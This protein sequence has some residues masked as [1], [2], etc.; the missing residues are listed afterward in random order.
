MISVAFDIGT[1]NLGVAA[2]STNA[3]GE[4]T[5]IWLDT[6][7]IS[8][9]TADKCVVKLWEY[10]DIMLT[11]FP[12][13]DKLIVLI[14]AQPSKARSLMRSVEL[15]VRH[16]FMMRNHQKVSK[17]CVKSV[18][19]RSKLASAVQYVPGSS[20]A[21]RYKARKNASVTEVKSAFRNLPD[22]L[23]LLECCK[24]DDACDATLYLIRDGATNFVNISSYALCCH[25]EKEA[26]KETEKLVKITRKEEETSHRERVQHEKRAAKE[27]TIQEKLDAKEAVRQEKLD[28]KEAVRQEKLAANEAGRQE[29]LAAKEAGRQEKTS[30]R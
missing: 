5:L 24:A 12:P 28:A 19:P 23:G 26:V 20:S 22:A 3:A 27:A 2:C 25:T 29:K 7:D 21:Q 8:S 15:G 13:Q 17:T 18:S 10:L 1:K 4:S 30:A 6:A 14:E 16:Y 9:T 11:K